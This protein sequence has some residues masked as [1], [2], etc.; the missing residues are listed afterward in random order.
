MIIVIRTRTN[1]KHTR[2]C[3]MVDVVASERLDRFWVT[4]GIVVHEKCLPSTAYAVRC[5]VHRATPWAY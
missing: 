2:E 5:M 4:P 1:P 3:V